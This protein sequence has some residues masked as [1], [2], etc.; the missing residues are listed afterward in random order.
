MVRTK[1][2]RVTRAIKVMQRLANIASNTIEIRFEVSAKID[3]FVKGS[4]SIVENYNKHVKKFSER[5]GKKIGKEIYDDNF[6]KNSDKY[7]VAIIS[8]GESIEAHYYELRD[9]EVEKYKKYMERLEDVDVDLYYFNPF[10]Q[11]DFL[12]SK[13]IS[14]NDKRI[15]QECEFLVMPEEVIKKKEKDFEIDFDDEDKPKTEETK[16]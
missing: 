2:G 8:N 16:K 12:G 11:E 5:F 13:G 4:E 10:T 3:D 15:L 6:K 9:K 7:S 14:P 1:V